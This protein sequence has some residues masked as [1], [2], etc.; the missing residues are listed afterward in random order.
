MARTEDEVVQILIDL[1]AEDFGGKRGQ[2][3]LISWG[4]IRSI[5]GFARL[6]ETRFSQLV[7]AAVRRRLYLWD[8]GEG[9]NGRLVAVARMRTVDRWRRVPKRIIQAYRL[10]P[11]DTGDTLEDD[12]E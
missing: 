4:D 10:D 5:Y 7:E 8:L 1:Y 12:S 6:F 2:R 9:E 11:D 3:Y